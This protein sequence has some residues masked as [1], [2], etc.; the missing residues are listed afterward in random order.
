MTDCKDPSPT[1]RNRR[2]LLL[3]GLLA[4]A[5][6]AAGAAQVKSSEKT[7]TRTLTIKVNY[8]GAGTVDDKHKIFLFVFDSPDF[9]Q[10]G[11]VPIAS[12]TASSKTEAVTL[13]ELTTSPVYLVASFTP[14]GSY[15][16]ESGPP[17]S[18]SSMGMYSKTP[19][20]PEPVKIEPGKTTEIDL[21]F[22]DSSKMP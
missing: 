12:K 11:V 17:P 1:M 6:L 18:G 16:G 15:D 2:N 21:A 14:D 8:T 9:V 3:A 19:G 13:T 4:V 20:T 22:D 5:C 10:G 7:D